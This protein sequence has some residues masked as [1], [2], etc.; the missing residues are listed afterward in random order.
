MNPENEPMHSELV[1]LVLDLL[2]QA[3]IEQR[4]AFP[5]LAKIEE[6]KNSIL[7]ELAQARDTED[8]AGVLDKADHLAAV[9][10]ITGWA[11]SEA[12]PMQDYL[13]ALAA[14]KETEW[15]K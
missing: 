10:I 9:R 14:R 4:G 11:R 5:T 13:A 12:Q 2:R 15:V 7:K 1:D 6:T 8:R 3:Q